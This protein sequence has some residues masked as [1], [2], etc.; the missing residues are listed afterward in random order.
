MQNI[1]TS[2]LRKLKKI[3]GLTSN[4]VFVLALCACGGS[5]SDSA[6]THLST[7]FML[8]VDISSIPEL[9]DFGNI[10]FADTN[11][12]VKPILDILKAHGVNFIRLR[13]FVNP[14]AK[15]GYASSDNAP[16][17]NSCSGRAQ[18]YNNKARLIAFAKEIKNAGFGLL[19]NIQYSDTWADPNSQIIPEAWRGI[20]SLPRMA[21]QV[22]SYT[23]DLVSSLKRAGATPD[24]VQVGNEITPGMLMHVPTNTSNCWGD[25]AVLNQPFNGSA[26]NW[27]NF[28]TLLKAGIQGVKEVDNNIAVMLHI[29]NTGSLSGMQWWVDNALK[30]GVRFDVLGLSAY[31]AFQ[32]PSNQ[33]PSSMRAMADKYPHLQFAFAEY[34]QPITMVNEL[35]MQLPNGQ[36]RGTFFWEPTRSGFWGD[37]IFNWDNTTAT[38][39]QERFL[40]F[41]NFAIKY[42]LKDK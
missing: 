42:G 8:G 28:A 35:M 37:A 30:R 31:E 11:G 39:D 13:T 34:N 3:I 17:E 2:L 20:G 22:H 14:S 36:G 24:M 21:L 40:E 15:Y 16:D 32:G 12:S 33:W 41:N 6:N 9:R 19:V 26:E 7:E 38:A 27:D 18:P 5:S 1:K 25:N 23:Q 10:Q 4:C 29:E